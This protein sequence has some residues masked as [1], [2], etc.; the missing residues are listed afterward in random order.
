MVALSSSDCS[1]SAV[2]MSTTNRT[3]GASC[4]VNATLVSTLGNEYVERLRWDEPGASWR[5]GQPCSAGACLS[6]ALQQS[7][8]ASRP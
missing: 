3:L 2:V 6:L 7:M 4:S 1:I 5:A 8:G